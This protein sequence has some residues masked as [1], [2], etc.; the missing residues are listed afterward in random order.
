MND[1]TQETIRRAGGADLNGLAELFDLYRQFYGRA[2]DVP[3]ARRFLQSRLER[4]E[5]VVFVAQSDEGTLDGFVLLYPTFSSIAAQGAWILND[6]Y[7]R[8][9]RRRCGLAERLIRQVKA[10]A[11]T[12]ECVRITL[13]TATDNHPAQ[14]LYRRMGFVRDDKYYSYDLVASA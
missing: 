11:K 5:A 10:F 1:K 8:E 3:L 4:E 12:T 7:V 2:S 14:S 13:K 6:L 9:Q